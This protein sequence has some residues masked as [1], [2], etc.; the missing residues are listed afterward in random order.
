MTVVYGPSATLAAPAVA[1][2]G[3]GSWTEVVPSRQV[4]TQAA[5]GFNA[6]D[7]R[8]PQ[9]VL[10]VPPPDVTRKLDEEDLVSTILNVRTLARARVGSPHDIRAQGV[11]AEVTPLTLLHASGPLHVDPAGTGAITAGTKFMAY[12]RVEPDE[13]QDVAAALRAPI[14]DPL[15][16]LGRQWQ[17]GEHRG[18]DAS[19]PVELRCETSTAALQSLD[20]RVGRP[21]A[22]QGAIDPS[23]VPAEALLEADTT[24]WWTLG[25]RIRLGRRASEKLDQLGVDEAHRV[26][27]R[28]EALPPPYE[29]HAGAIDGRAVYQAGLLAGESIWAEVHATAPDHWRADR[30]DYAADFAAGAGRL[31]IDGHDGG[32]VDWWSADA[33][34]V[35]AATTSTR[36]IV[37]SRLRYPGAAL[38]RY[39]QIEDDGRDPTGV[40]PDAAHWA[41]ALWIDA[42]A[43]SGSDWFSAPVASGP[44]GTGSIVTLHGATVRDSFDEWWPL[45]FPA[46]LG[47]PPAAQPAWSLY[48]TRGLPAGA[49]VLWPAALATLTSAPLDEVW[50]GVDEDADLC[51]AV[52]VC[53]DGVNVDRGASAPPPSEAARRYLLAPSWGI[54]AHGHPYRIEPGGPEGRRFVQGLVADLSGPVPRLR[55]GPRT[56]LLSGGSA[57]GRGHELRPSAVPSVGIRLV[58]RWCLTRGT[59][60][61]PVLWLQRDRSPLP[62]GPASHLRFDVLVPD[63]EAPDG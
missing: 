9:A 41:T 38:P 10:V 54:P 15:W 7:A 2:W 62:A 22:P 40:P 49:L 25:R 44:A 6:P 57:S 51:W 23:A 3:L 16:L 17:F 27:L 4:T 34:V 63:R 47:D 11:A 30:L 46:G 45:A 55:P 50:L 8:A 61:R 43:S 28:F 48:R 52:E 1:V 31:R 39:W 53:I 5:F 18:E 56:P 26:S 33:T 36:S 42:V 19:S 35:P 59:D 14:A 58:R 20:K 37:P 60:G 21:G 32:D 12:E 13:L 24:S 29:L